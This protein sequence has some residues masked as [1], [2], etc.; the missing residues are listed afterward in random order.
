MVHVIIKLNSYLGTRELPWHTTSSF[1][2]SKH[3]ICPLSPFVFLLSPSL[4]HY[5]RS[6]FHFS[7]Y[8]HLTFPSRSR[9]PSSPPRIS[10]S[11]SNSFDSWEGCN[12]SMRVTRVC[13]CTPRG[14]LLRSLPPACTVPFSSSSNAFFRRTRRNST[15]HT[16]NSTSNPAPT[17]FLFPPRLSTFPST[18]IF[19]TVPFP[20][21]RRRH[22]RRSSFFTFPPSTCPILRACA[23]SRPLAVYALNTC[24]HVGWHRFFAKIEA[25]K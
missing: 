7:A 22:L 13:A 9:V 10:F 20:P 25:R 17:L 4:S 19:L 16:S 2:V 3:D 21:L 15:L 12:P 23:R 24:Q 1:I 11:V 8:P 14:V 6:F 18:S 5:S